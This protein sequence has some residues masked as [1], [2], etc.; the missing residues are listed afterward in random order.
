MKEKFVSSSRAALPGEG[1]APAAACRGRRRFWGVAQEEQQR[2]GV[3]NADQAGRV[4][5]E[6]PS[7][8]RF[9][10]DVPAEPANDDTSINGCLMDAHR[11]RTSAES[12]VVGDERKCGG[13]VTRLADP[14]Q[15]ARP[16]QA[17]IGSDVAGRPG[18]R[19]PDKQARADGVA[20]AEP[21]GEV[22]ADWTQKGVDPLELGEHV[23]PVRINANARDVGHHGELHRRKHL[24]VEVVEQR[25]R[26]EQGHDE[27]RGA[28]A[29]GGGGRRFG[30]IHE[31]LIS[32]S[33]CATTLPGNGR[34]GGPRRWESP[35]TC[36][37]RPTEPS[38][39]GP[40][41]PRP[42]STSG[43]SAQNEESSC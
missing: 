25:D 12:V 6:P 1:F 8:L 2:D 5:R 18:D 29:A 10:R 15:R 14:H 13:D 40:A 43:S 33:G 22:S 31:G 36:S 34:Q 42:L 27:P 41:V 9:V 16:E 26:E 4:E 28:G 35:T 37:T 32:S 20:P 11:A 3:K 17:V 30:V 7:P 23:A 21:V 39:E 19:R 38:P 24:A